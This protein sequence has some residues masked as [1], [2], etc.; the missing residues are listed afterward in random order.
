MKIILF[1]S[2][3]RRH[4]FIA[5]N[6]MKHCDDILII[7]ECKPNDESEIIHDQNNSIERHFHERNKNEKL[8]FPDDDY[9]YG[10]TFPI[11]YKEVNSVRIEKIIT[12]FC[13]DVGF[14]YGSSIISDKLIKLFP[15]NKLINLH[16][17][18]SPYYRGAGTNFWP[19]VNNELEY[20]GSTFLHLD[21]GIDTGDIICHV[22]PQFKKDDNVHTVGFKLIKNSLDVLFH[23]I[24]MLKQNKKLNKIKQWEVNDPKYYKN[25]DFDKKALQHYHEN[26][27]NHVID[28]HIQNPKKIKLIELDP[29]YKLFT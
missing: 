5:N 12:D 28:T 21:P 29:D 6:I 9:F 15:K 1:T 14:V 11:I 22:R 4:K 27:M 2:N 16:L 18:I 19:F 10:K 25:S 8:F 23:I 13:P 7:S 3:S 17:G 26:L 24:E 20:V